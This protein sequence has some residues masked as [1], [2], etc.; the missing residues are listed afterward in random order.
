[1][2]HDYAYRYE[3]IKAFAE[4]FLPTEVFCPLLKIILLSPVFVMFMCISE[5]RVFL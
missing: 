1:M 3:E 2:T 4:N 5:S